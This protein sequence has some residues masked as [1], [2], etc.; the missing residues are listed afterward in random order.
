MMLPPPPPLPPSPSPVSAAAAQVLVSAREYQNNASTFRLGNTVTPSP[1]NH[2]LQ[3]VNGVL[4]ERQQARTLAAQRSDHMIAV[5][6][7][8]WRVEGYS[9]ERAVHLF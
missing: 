1:S 8:L 7:S 3:K 9:K 2:N 6:A 4:K 5:I